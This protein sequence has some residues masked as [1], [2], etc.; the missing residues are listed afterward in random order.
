M[1]YLITV[2]S[3]LALSLWQCSATL[4]DEVAT[5]DRFIGP[6]PHW[7]DVKRDYQA[8]GDGKADDT[9]ALQ[10]ALA[11]IQKEGGFKTLYLPAG[12]Y[13]LT[14]TINMRA[15]ENLRIVGDDPT[16][17]VLKWDGQAGKDMFFFNG[18][19][20][21]FLSRVTIDGQDKA[22]VGLHVGIDYVEGNFFPTGWGIYDVRFMN[23]KRGV[24]AGNPNCQSEA[25]YERCVFRECETGFDMVD[26]NTANVWIRHC[27]FEDCGT[28]IRGGAHGTVL[29]SVFRRSKNLDIGDG[30]LGYFGVRNCFSIGSKRF[31][32]NHDQLDGRPGVFQGNRIIDPVEPMPI[33]LT[34]AGTVTFIDNV[35]RSPENAEAPVI[36]RGKKNNTAAIFVGNTFTTGTPET[37]IRTFGPGTTGRIVDNRIVD[38]ET[39][40]ATEPQ[41]PQAPPRIPADAAF[42]FQPKAF[43]GEA[44]QTAI[45]QAVASGHK[46]PVVYLKA[47]DY[48]LRDTVTI[49]AGTA[50]MVTGDTTSWGGPVKLNW[51][52]QGRGPMVRFAGPGNRATLE[53]VYM[54]GN[55]QASGIIIEQ[56]DQPNGRVYMER[57]FSDM[58]NLPLPRVGVFMDG[59]DWTRLETYGVGVGGETWFKVVG[60]SKTA[61]GEPTTAGY[62]G[63]NAMFGA[64]V[65]DKHPV[66]DVDKNGKLLLCDNWFENGGWPHRQPILDLDQ[67]KSGSVTLQGYK[68][69]H[70]TRGVGESTNMKFDGFTGKVSILNIILQNVVVEVSGDN[71]EQKLFFGTNT[72]AWGDPNGA[73]PNANAKITLNATKG[74]T[75]V[76]NCAQAYPDFSTRPSRRVFAHTYPYQHPI[77]DPSA[78]EVREMFAHARAD[79]P[80]YGLADV[81]QGAT[82]V[83]LRWVVL[84]KVIDTGV[85]IDAK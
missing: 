39:I 10:T 17:V 62:Q 42:V 78:E 14:K 32:E 30:N 12:T 15:A 85:R 66:L 31:Y 60:G 68:M 69:Q 48:T 11:D 75:S 61:A 5:P 13:R 67:S 50:L 46:Q 16:K 37:A 26:A 74:R 56:A 3:M 40:D 77:G 73:V 24:L 2:C 84:Q 64:G 28:A 33:Y 29:N 63:W 8:A 65:S 53:H 82:D 51:T 35:I 79:K 27:L 47:G 59:L 38:R 9:S 23:L 55:G 72:L 19:R 22:G 7:L 81:P 54:V 57:V 76:V 49:P 18:V 6:F 20:Q 21:S 58:F 34:G 43:T 1:R 45:D 41:L 25:V 44:I 80:G 36:E 83:R 70:H 71:P 4:A 52:G